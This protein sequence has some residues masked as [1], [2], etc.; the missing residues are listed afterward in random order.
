MKFRYFEDDRV[1]LTDVENKKC[2]GKLIISSFVTDIEI[3][4]LNYNES[5]PLRWCNFTEIFVD[6]QPGRWFKDCYELQRLDLSSFNTSN[7]VSMKSMFSRCYSL[8]QL[9]LSS[10]D[11]TSVVEL[12]NMFDG[13]KTDEI[14]GIDKLINNLNKL[15]LYL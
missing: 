14:Q 11:T 5:S 7:T 13:C 6:N 4:T 15:D 8:E 1:M 9:D 10:F 2:T 12:T 3:K